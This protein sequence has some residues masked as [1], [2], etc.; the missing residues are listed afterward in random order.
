MK[1]VTKT[2][3]FFKENWGQI[4]WMAGLLVG[5]WQAALVLASKLANKWKEA[6]HDDQP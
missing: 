2:V 6:G 3:E 5:L 4:K 1:Y